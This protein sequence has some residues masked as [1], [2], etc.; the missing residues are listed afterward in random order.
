[1][2]LM[3]IHLIWNTHVEETSVETKNDWTALW[4][5]AGIKNVKNF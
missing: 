3:R 2:K 1:M 5:A 4:V